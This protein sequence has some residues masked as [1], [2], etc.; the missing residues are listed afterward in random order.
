MHIINGTLL[1]VVRYMDCYHNRSVLI[2]EYH[3]VVYFPFDEQFLD[4]ENTRIVTL[5]FDD[6]LFVLINKNAAMDGKINIKQ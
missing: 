5:L 3:I 6:V 1:G 2:F 4:F